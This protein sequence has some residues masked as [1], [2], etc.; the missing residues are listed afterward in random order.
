MIEINV[1]GAMEMIQA[2]SGNAS[3]EFSLEKAL[4]KMAGDWAG[5]QFHCNAYK[6]TGGCYTG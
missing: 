4:E 3:K 1:M 5:V 6:D 2:I